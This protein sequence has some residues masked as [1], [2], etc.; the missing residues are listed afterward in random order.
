M[1]WG[2]NLVLDWKL[3]PS[4]GLAP[5]LLYL[6]ADAGSSVPTCQHGGVASSL[7]CWRKPRYSCLLSSPPWGGEVARVWVTGPL[8]S[9]LEHGGHPFWIYGTSSLNWSPGPYPNHL[10]L[11]TV[12]KV[13][14]FHCFPRVVL[15]HALP[16]Q[17]AS[18]CHS[19]DIW[20][21]SLEL[22]NSL[23]GLHGYRVF[24][25][26]H[27][28]LN[29]SFMYVWV[30]VSNFFFIINNI[31]GTSLEECFCRANKYEHLSCWYIM[32]NW[33]PQRT[34]TLHENVFPYSPAN[35]GFR[36]V[37]IFCLYGSKKKL[38]TMPICIWFLAAVLYFFLKK[39]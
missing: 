37:F 18:F 20:S 25:G 8:P 5:E 10:V 7:R 11:H 23:A 24:Y 14:S 16:S 29:F 34:L 36:P 1:C 9:I 13:E 4:V 15:N 6:H 21:S 33:S 38:Y 28:L 27:N 30:V 12:G 26:Y 17:T 19:C 2:Q 31:Q 32:S 39:I 35:M 3:C 22:P